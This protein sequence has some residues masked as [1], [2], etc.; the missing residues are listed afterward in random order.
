MTA[1]AAPPLPS[2]LVASR[3]LPLV[4]R[5]PE[6]ETLEATWAEVME[7]RRQVVFVGG[8]PGAGK[9][10][11]AAEAAGGHHAVARVDDG[12]R[13]APV[14]LAHRPE[15]G[16]PP[17]AARQVAGPAHHVTVTSRPPRRAAAAAGPEPPQSPPGGLGGPRRRGGRGCPRSRRSC[18]RSPP[19]P[20]PRRRRRRPASCRSRSY[21]FHSLSQPH[22]TRMFHV[23]VMSRHRRSGERF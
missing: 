3:R 9:T 7:A 2:R 4:G 10:R 20:V 16:R 1:W 13:V 18:R 22:R 23:K 6:L 14:R 17:D 8:E 5:R 11:L 15:G 21:P 19:A 12:E